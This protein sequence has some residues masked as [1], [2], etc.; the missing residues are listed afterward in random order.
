MNFLKIIL[1]FYFLWLNLIFIYLIINFYFLI[2]IFRQNETLSGQRQAFLIREP[3]FAPIST[4][5]KQ[6]AT[7]S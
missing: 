3:Y 7:D 2:C 6:Q 4:I 5:M 1:K